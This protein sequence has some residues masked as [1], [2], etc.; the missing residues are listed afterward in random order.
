MHVEGNGRLSIAC[1]GLFYTLETLHAVLL[2]TV[3][4]LCLS[5]MLRAT[6]FHNNHDTTTTGCCKNL[7][8]YF[9]SF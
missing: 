7:K 9:W 8:F 6:T 1:Q 3:T 2:C 4:L 5:T